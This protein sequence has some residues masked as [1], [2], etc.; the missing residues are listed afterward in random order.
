MKKNKREFPTPRCV[1]C[2]KFVSY[3]DIEK[4]KAKMYFEP[5]T[6]FNSEQIWC[7]HVECQSA[8]R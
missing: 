6:E 5:D 4:K 3:N 2:G 7:E 1:Y 8:T